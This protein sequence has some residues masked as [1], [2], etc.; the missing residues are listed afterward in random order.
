MSWDTV[1][2]VNSAAGTAPSVIL[3]MGVSGS[4]KTT[5]GRELAA[6]L[7][8]TF[9]EADDYHSAANVARMRS[10]RPLDDAA[11]GP[12]LQRVHDA[13]RTSV[14]AGA[15]VVVACSALK[16]S[17]REV[18][19]D[20]VADA[21][22]VYLRVDRSILAARLRAR[23][24]HFMPASLLDSQLATLEVPEDAIVIDASQSPDVVVAK[25]KLELAP[26]GED[27]PEG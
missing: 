25:L 11:R 13:I 1:A 2:G 23:H 5:I 15:R 4:G 12:W 22:V 14:A 20:G 27:A 3:V 19:L 17:Y 16:Q 21:A 6:G 7:G 9:L 10:G 18:L 26:G 24:G 8:S